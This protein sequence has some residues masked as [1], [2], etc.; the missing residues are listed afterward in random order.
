MSH[1]QGFL[2]A[3]LP[4]PVRLPRMSAPLW[5]AA[6]A[7]TAVAALV[8]G[9]WSLAG[10]AALIAGLLILFKPEVAIYLLAFSVPLGSLAVGD[11]ES[12]SFAVGPTEAIAGLLAVGWIARS[13][14]RKRLVV[15][16]TPLSIPLLGMVII[17]ALSGFQATNLALTLKETL[18]WLELVLVYLFIVAEMGTTRQALTLLLL[19]LAGAATEALVGTV[20]FVLGIGP[21]FFAIGRFMRAYGTFDQPN[22]YAGYL[23]MLIPLAV[24]LLLSRPSPRVRNYTLATGL[25]AVAAV[26]MSLSRGAWVG[27]ALGL[28]LMMLFWS[29]RS[30]VLFSIGLIAAIPLGTMAFMNVLPSEVSS[31]LATALDYFRFIDVTKEE[32][33]TQ[34]WAV[35]ERVAHWQAAIDMIRAHPLFGVGAGNYPAVYEWYAVQGWPE[36]LGHAHNFYLN[37]AAET[38]IPG[39]LVYLSFV[40][41]AL[42]SAMVW[43]TRSGKLPDLTPQ[44]PSP[45]G[46]GESAPLPVS[47]R[48]GHALWHVH[49]GRGHHSPLFWRGILLGVLGSLVASSVHN[50]FDNLFVHSM[51]VQLGMILGLAQLSANA[52]FSKTSRPAPTSSFGVNSLHEQ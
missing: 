13:L 2:G 23:G 42:V 12:S 20:Q 50:M 4:A 34:N 18:K 29:R 30:R 14:A 44:P 48:R 3:L 40:L 43:L 6:I 46:N 1:S 8:P 9:I 21:E 41:T 15:P 17:V 11:R 16:F 51:S 52:L 31:R 45:R 5:L 32:V 22:P 38:G 26:G 36:A 37:M 47:G 33:T 39:L 19:L 28:F 49:G 25:L 27:I 10:L 7:L 35:I 24:G